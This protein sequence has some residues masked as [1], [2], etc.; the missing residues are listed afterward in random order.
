MV[1]M[2]DS[3]IDFARLV[4]WGSLAKIGYL[5]LMGS[6][7]GYILWNQAVNRIGVLSANMY[8]YM[9]PLVT[10]IVSAIALGEKITLM[11]FCGIILVVFGMVFASLQ[12]KQS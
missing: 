11:G 8:I 3:S 1:L 4:T 10:L 7:V 9:I 6:A 5:G 2:S 12:K